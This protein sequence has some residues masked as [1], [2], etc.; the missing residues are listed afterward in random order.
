MCELKFEWEKH[1]LLH[2]TYQTC[3]WASSETSG[4]TDRSPTLPARQTRCIAIDGLRIKTSDAQPA[5]TLKVV[6]ADM[7]AAQ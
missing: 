6:T 3:E 2:R 7:T 1:L 4:T 5:S